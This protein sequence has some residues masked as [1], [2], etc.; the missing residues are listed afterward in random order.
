MMLTFIEM[1]TTRRIEYGHLAFSL[2]FML[3]EPLLIHSLISTEQYGIAA[4]NREM[5]GY[6]N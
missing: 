3:F 4:E 5:F 2:T 1:S 6:I